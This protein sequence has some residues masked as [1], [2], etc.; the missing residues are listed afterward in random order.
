MNAL[1]TAIVL[2][3]S[4]NFDL[5]ATY[6]HPSV[7]LVPTT[8]MAAL[9]YRGLMYDRTA[10]T[11][12]GGNVTTPLHQGHDLVSIY[13]D[14]RKTIYLPEG[15]TGT[16]PAE[17][18]VLVHEMVHHLQNV[19]GLKY[20]CPEEREKLAYTAQERWLG[21]FGRDLSDEFGIDGLT[22]LVRTNC[23]G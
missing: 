18:S 19:A 11:A 6:I 20:N 4:A 2:W 7:E 8:Q 9:R 23:M 17:L 13:H 15:W 16:T 3:L 21:L 14:K 10:H 22:V 12:I 5:P 1:L